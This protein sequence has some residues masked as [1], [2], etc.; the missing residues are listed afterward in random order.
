M[1]NNSPCEVS[2]GNTCGVEVKLKRDLSMWEVLMIGLGPTLGTTI[3]MLVGPGIQIAGTGLVLVFTLNFIITVFTAMAYMELSSAFPDTGGGYLWV[4]EGMPQPF[5]FLAGWMSWFGHCIVTSFY[6]LGFG[7]G[8]FWILEGQGYNVPNADMLVKAMAVAVGLIFLYINYRGTK[9]TG[10]SSII[11]AGIL[12]VIIVLFIAA[13]FLYLMG[14][15]DMGGAGVVV[16]N[17]V[18]NGFPALLIAMGFTFIVFE[19]YEIISQCGEEC[20]DPL[21]NVPRAMWLCI[22]ISTIIFI[23]VAIVTIGATNIELDPLTNEFGIFLGGKA[24]DDPHDLVAQVAGLTMPGFGMLLIGVGIILGTLAA[25]NSTIFSSSRVSFAMGRDGALP[26]SFGRLH[27]KKNTPYIAIFSSGAIIITMTV[28]L[29]IEE[30]VAAADIMFLLLFFFVNMTAISLRVR[31][32][33]IKRHTIMPFFPWV[34][35]IGIIT[36]LVLAIGLWWRFQNA[37]FIAIAWISVGLTTYYFYGGKKEI[38]TVGQEVVEKKGIVETLKEKPQDKKYRIL[39]PVMADDHK[40]LVEFAALVGRVEDA[41]LHIVTVIEI[42]SGTPLNSLKYRHTAPHIKLIERMKK[43]S[44]RE[45]VKSRGTVLISHAASDSIMDTIKEDRVNLLVM[46]WK[47]A[48]GAGRIMGT[49]IDRL[50]Q[51]ADCDTV[52]FKIAGLGKKIKKILVIS[53]PEWHSSYA[54]G[55]AVLIAK[56]DDSEITIFSAS[57]TS[58]DVASQK[59]Y[60]KR[61]SDLCITHSIEHRVSVIKTESIK[62]AIVAESEY[63]DLIVMGAGRDWEQKNYA[64]GKLQ[65]S[66]AKSIDKPMLMVRKI[67]KN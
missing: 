14:Q 63:Y 35:I 48:A 10:K 36:K 29:P 12:L 33:D 7:K 30:I 4:K 2:E 24:I 61:L 9:E 55:Y 39:V 62:E 67:Q 56:R 21:K 11:I 59:I 42:P 8:L 34:P 66:L 64:F 60:A 50:V 6:V 3:F 53:T 17:P 49:T 19:G 47:G 45:L 28:L 51:G 37:W 26:K 13:G 1:A 18:P 23:L 31:R 41:D 52:V 25:I 27:S 65:D 22:A 57:T 16:S 54:T 43:A 40:P 32:P 38:E 46:G 15:P 20:K 5:G 44:D 58:E